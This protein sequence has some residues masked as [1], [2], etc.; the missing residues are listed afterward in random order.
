VTS[1]IRR[2]AQRA[3][4]FFFNLRNAFYERGGREVTTE[5]VLNV[6]DRR[7]EDAAKTTRDLTAAMASGRI[8]LAQWRESIAVELRRAHAQAY[9]LGRGG[10]DRMTDADR[11]IVTARLRSEFGYLRQFAKDVQAGGL[12]EAQIRV[13]AEMYAHHV[14]V[15]LWEG[16]RE[17]KGDAGKTQERRVMS[18][19]EHCSD[20]EDMASEGWKPLNHFPPPGIDSQCMANCRCSMEFR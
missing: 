17:A 2:I 20:C 14:R 15:S 9:A 16:T 8:T 13:R 19:A 6:V 4:T 11:A 12:S 1:I 10:W 7:I 18:Q 3:E 5:D